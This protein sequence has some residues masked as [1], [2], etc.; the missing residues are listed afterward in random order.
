MPT[1]NERQ[2]QSKNEQNKLVFI[3]HGKPMT[4]SRDIAKIFEKEHRNVTRGIDT[5]LEEGL[6]VKDML[7]IE[8]IF[9]EIDPSIFLLKNFV[10]V[11]SKDSYG[12]DLTEYHMTKDGFTLVV[13]GYTGAKAIAFKMAYIEKFNEMETRLRQREEKQL[14]TMKDFVRIGGSGF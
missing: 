2:A 5:L 11:N 9:T 7:K 1:S 14:L 3:E 12:R 4:T 13:M 8:H 10:R 6:K